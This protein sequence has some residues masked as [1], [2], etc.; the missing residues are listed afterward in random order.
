MLFLTACKGS[1][2]LR[3]GIIF[4]HREAYTMNEVNSII[5]VTTALYCAY[6]TIVTYGFII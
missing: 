1:Q 2:K 3:N 6:F 4:V 5:Q